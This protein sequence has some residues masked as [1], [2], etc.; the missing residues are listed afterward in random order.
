MVTS[1]AM[2]LQVVCNTTRHACEC[3][4]DIH[5]VSVRKRECVCVCVYLCMYI[6]THTHTH[7][8]TH[9]SHCAIQPGLGS[10]PSP[11]VGAGAKKRDFKAVCEMMISR[12]RSPVAVHPNAAQSMDVN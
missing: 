9:A 11:V 5:C 6:C 2:M 7:T 12:Y 4:Y 3:E 8:H 10:P 1:I